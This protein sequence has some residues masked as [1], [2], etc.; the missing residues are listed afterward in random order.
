MRK[1][2]RKMPA[3]SLLLFKNYMPGPRLY[4]QGSTLT[5]FVPTCPL[6]RLRPA[7]LPL[8]AL[9]P[10]KKEKAEG[11]KGKRNFPFPFWPQKEKKRRS[12]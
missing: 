10:G 12:E 7:G 9:G 6:G 11:G 5:A 8:T 2:L 3:L 4:G 1:E